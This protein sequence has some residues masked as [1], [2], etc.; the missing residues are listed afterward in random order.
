MEAEMFTNFSEETQRF[1]FFQKIKDINHEMLVRYTQN[2]YDR[3]IAIIAEVSE[4]GKKRM[5]GV[6]RLMGDAYNETAEFAIVIADPWHHIGLGNMMTDYI[7]D[8]ARDRGLSKVYANV[9]KD[10]HIMLHIFEKRGFS[11][12]IEDDMCYAELSL[13]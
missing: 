2:D 12:R 1:R 4:K 10:N 8:I 6:V 9:L 5:A 11:V 3:E 13:K 7:L